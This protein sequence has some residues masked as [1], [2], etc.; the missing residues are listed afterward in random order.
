MAKKILI[1]DDDKDIVETIQT[2]LTAH[3]YDVDVAYSIEDGE[4]KNK[5]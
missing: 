5:Q 1:I 4:S 3:E 2:V